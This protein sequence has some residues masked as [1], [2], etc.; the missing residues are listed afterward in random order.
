MRAIEIAA[1]KSANRTEEKFLAVLNRQLSEERNLRETLEQRLARAEDA[2][3]RMVK[4]PSEIIHDDQD[5]NSAPA[6]S[7]SISQ[8]KS[9][10]NEKSRSFLSVKLSLPK[11]L[12]F[13][14]IIVIFSFAIVAQ[15]RSA[16]S[17]KNKQQPE[18]SRFGVTQPK[19]KKK[20]IDRS[21]TLPEKSLDAE[22]N[23]AGQLSALQTAHS[24][25][26][27]SQI[28]TKKELP[29]ILNL[30]ANTSTKNL[31][32][33]QTSSLAEDKP[34]MYMCIV[35]LANVRGGP[36]M[37]APIVGRLKQGDKV[38]VI[39]K[40]GNW[41]QFKSEDGLPNWIHSSLMRRQS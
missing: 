36:S 7:H 14:F 19:A 37:K 21:G 24:G 22:A 6:E 41:M 39:G 34:K 40:T 23:S 28:D 2:L 33:M 17:D 29:S 20:D 8:S 18:V 27:N 16:E 4:V 15:W 35:G 26:S 13:F 38:E 30:P 3:E 32:G 11:M 25:D 10:L 31:T 5:R 1:S 12:L 9:G